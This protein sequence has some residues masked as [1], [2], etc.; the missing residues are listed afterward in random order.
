VVNVLHEGFLGGVA[1]GHHPL[2]AA[3]AHHFQER[4]LKVKV[5]HLERLKLHEPD[6]VSSIIRTMAMLRAPHELCSSRSAKMTAISSWVSGSMSFR[7]TGLFDTGE[8]SHTTPTS[9]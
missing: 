4:F 6:S 9:N 8:A 3:L 5:R 2:R 7:G 1:E